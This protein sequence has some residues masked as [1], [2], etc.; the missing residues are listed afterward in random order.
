MIP[1]EFESEKSNPGGGALTINVNCVVL[2]SPPPVPVTVIMGDPVGVEDEVVIVK[3]L[4]KVG[5]PENGLNEQEAPEGT[6]LVQ[7]KLTD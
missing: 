2:V 4:E 6:P 1:P 3:V 7:D 5:F